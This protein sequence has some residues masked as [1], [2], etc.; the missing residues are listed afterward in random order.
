LI[1]TIVSK[2]FCFGELDKTNI[3]HLQ[4]DFLHLHK[5]FAWCMHLLWFGCCRLKLAA[6]TTFCSKSGTYWIVS[7]WC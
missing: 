2:G 3:T 7:V 4:L 1:P 5:S 6:W